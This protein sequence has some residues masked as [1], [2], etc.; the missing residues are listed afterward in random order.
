MS[1]YNGLKGYPIAWDSHNNGQTQIQAGKGKI[2][3]KIRGHHHDFYVVELWSNI[4]ED[5]KIA[6]ISPFHLTE[7]DNS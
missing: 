2:I 4:P 5:R 6:V 3:D 7:I 1:D